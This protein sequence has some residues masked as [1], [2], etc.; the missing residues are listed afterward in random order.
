MILALPVSLVF[1]YNAKDTKKIPTQPGWIE[2]G[3][4]LGKWEWFWERTYSGSSSISF[5]ATTSCFL[6]LA[7]A[8][9]L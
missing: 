1:L 2:L 8:L 6:N 7:S 5:I 9:S 4:I 3:M